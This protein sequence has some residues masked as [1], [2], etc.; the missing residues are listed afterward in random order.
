MVA[1]VE[2]SRIRVATDPP[3]RAE[4]LPGIDHLRGV[5]IVLMALDHVRDFFDADALRFSPTDLSHTYPALFLT[6]FVTHY[7]A[8]TFALLAGIS[9][10]LHGRGSQAAG[11]WPDFC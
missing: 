7:C 8:P 3:Q 11:R 2:E 4:R 1:A 10:F 9:A 5:V 6:R